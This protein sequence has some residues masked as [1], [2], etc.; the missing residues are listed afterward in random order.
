MLV[1]NAVEE[2]RESW[3]KVFLVCCR[4][5]VPSRFHP[6]GL[7][8]HRLV[9]G[10]WQARGAINEAEWAA[11]KMLISAVGRPRTSSLPP[12]PYFS[13]AQ[14]PSCPQALTDPERP[15][16][17]LLWALRWNVLSPSHSPTTLLSSFVPVTA[18]HW[19]SAAPPVRWH[20]DASL[21]RLLGS[22]CFRTGPGKE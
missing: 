12:P 21:V 7:E 9:K 22:K 20:P 15:H 10:D 5:L 14:T 3:V 13:A 6:L 8:C 17:G 2:P 18:L 16:R 19:A 11:E 1:I 4:L